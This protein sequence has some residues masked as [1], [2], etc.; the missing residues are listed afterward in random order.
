MAWTSP[1][2]HGDSGTG[3]WPRQGAAAT[4]RAT[5]CQHAAAS[6]V[7]MTAAR[8]PRWIRRRRRYQLRLRRTLFPAT[9]F[10]ASLPG[11]FGQSSYG[12]KTT[13]ARC[14]PA[15]KTIS[16]CSLRSNELARKIGQW[17]QNC[18]RLFI[19]R[20]RVLYQKLHEVDRGE[21]NG[22]KVPAR[23]RHVASEKRTPPAL[24][25]GPTF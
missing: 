1:R 9:W 22:T 6:S 2:D 13:F 11:L 8:R 21:S 25:R 7:S 5:P 15:S 18:D 12:E 3:G 24:K 19:Q 17:Y 23:G 14:N 4:K 16:V 20:V 10:K